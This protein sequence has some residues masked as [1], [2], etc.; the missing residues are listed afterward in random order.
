MSLAGVEWC[1]ETSFADDTIIVKIEA[2]LAFG[3]RKKKKRFSFSKSS[4]DL[5][6][7]FLTAHQ[8]EK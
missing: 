5:M 2:L 6:H 3:L 4:I 1:L 8:G 7:L